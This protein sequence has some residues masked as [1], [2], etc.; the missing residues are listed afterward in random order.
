[1]KKIILCAIAIMAFGFANAQKTRFGVKGGL[2][3]ATIGG[4]DRANALVG[5]QLGGFAEVKVWKKL[6]IQPELLYSAQ[7][8]KFD[9]YYGE[10]DYTVNLNYINVP[11]LAKYYITKQF[12]VEA[13][14][15]LGV[16]V[17]SKNTY[18]E[19]SVD[20]GF[21]LGAGYNFTDNFS[22]GIRYTIGLTNVYR[23]EDEYYGDFGYYDN[24]YTN[25]VLALTAAYKF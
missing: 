10:R 19:K 23:Y 5:F 15:Q 17:S 2:N 1:M 18:D 9:G 13:G 12:T 14:P 3:I 11:V 25:N 7:G 4:D 22:V 6:Y 8:G 24:R 16:L 20:V 21:N